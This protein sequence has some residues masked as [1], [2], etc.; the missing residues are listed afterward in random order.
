MRG[1]ANPIF[2]LPVFVGCGIYVIVKLGGVMLPGGLTITK[3]DNPR[4]YWTVIGLSFATFA[5][6]TALAVFAALPAS[7][8]RG[9]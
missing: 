7:V 6:V 2:L 5:V 9:H 4:S 8:V 3:A 1:V